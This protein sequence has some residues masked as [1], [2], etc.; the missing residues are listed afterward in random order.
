MASIDVAPALS[1]LNAI[2]A[3]LQLIAVGNDALGN[4]IPGVV[5]TWSS[6]DIL[7]VTIDAVTGLATA[8]GSGTSTI[9]ATADGIAGSA[10]LTINL[11]GT[12]TNSLL[13]IADVIAND[14]GSGLYTT[15]FE[16]TLTDA[17][18]APASGGTVTITNS[19]GM[20]TLVEVVA[21]SGFYTAAA[22]DFVGGDYELDVVAGPH[23]VSNVVARGPGIHTITAP[24]VNAVHPADQDLIVTWTT[25][26][27]A[28]FARVETN[29]MVSG[30]LLDDGS[31]VI[32]GAD[33][34][35]EP[36]QFILVLR[37]N[38]VTIAGGLLG[39]RLQIE[40]EAEVTPVVIQ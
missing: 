21:G 18:G 17:F 28:Q 39:S 4:P 34:P 35:A 36:A 6:S 29:N 11:T 19:A 12:G 38:Q 23:S 7:V 8:V 22:F 25:P 16:V 10:S 24:I 3:T 5:F 2:G 40:I 30:L 14:I 37:T 13:V 1:E 15:D 33:N 26:S 20:T 31:F 9:S 32:A 27:Q